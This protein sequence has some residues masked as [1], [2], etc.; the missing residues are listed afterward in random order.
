MIVRI[1]G[2]DKDRHRDI[3]KQLFKLR[4]EIFVKERKW[5]LPSRQDFESDQY[6]GSQALYVCDVNDGVIEGHV[7][8]TPTIQASLL[9]DYYPHLVE[10][11]VSPRDPLIFE[12]T[13]YLVRPR[14][15][16]AA[17]NRAAK[18]KLLIGMLEWA[19]EQ[20]LTHIQ[21]VIDTHTFATFVEM[22]RETMPLGLS[23]AFGGGFDVPGGGECMAIRWPVS[24]RVVADLRDYGGLGPSKLNPHFGRY[25]TA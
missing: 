14:R 25:Q 2:A 1:S 18:A 11:T 21:T 24:D 13:R 22:T 5:S 17:N 16:S 12:A 10:G 7:R 4:Y 3:F 6:D 19:T 15:K 8:L 9:A 23:H 20:N